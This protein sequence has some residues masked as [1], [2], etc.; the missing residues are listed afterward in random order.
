MEGRDPLAPIPPRRRGPSEASPIIINGER[1]TARQA[2]ERYPQLRGYLQPERRLSERALHT[3]LRREFR[4]GRIPEHVINE[5]PP[6]FFRVENHYDGA[7]IRYKLDDP[8]IKFHDIVSLF[9]YLKTQILRLIEAHPNTKVGLN[10]N[11]LMVRRTTGAVERKGLFTGRMF[12][13]FRTPSRYLT[14]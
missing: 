14:R 5:D 12:E 13:N 4:N 7:E 10:V 2:L 8:R 11:T 9:E 6:E 3:R 1:L